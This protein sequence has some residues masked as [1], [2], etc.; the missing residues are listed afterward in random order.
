M[1]RFLPFLLLGLLTAPLFAQGEGDRIEGWGVAKFDGQ[2]DLDRAIAASQEKARLDLSANILTY[3]N[4]KTTDE[5]IQNGKDVRERFEKVTVTKV[6]QLLREVH[7]DRPQVDHETHLVTTRA[8]V[9]KATARQIIHDAME[10]LNEKRRRYKD[11]LDHVKLYTDGSRYY[12]KHRVLKLDPKDLDGVQREMDHL[13]ADLIREKL[14]DI[15]DVRNGVKT[16]FYWS[17]P[18][19]GQFTFVAY[20]GIRQ[21]DWIIKHYDEEIDRTEGFRTGSPF[22]MGQVDDPASHPDIAESV[23]PATRYAMFGFGDRFA[24]FAG[25]DPEFDINING[26]YFRGEGQFALRASLGFSMGSN[27][28]ISKTNPGASMDDFRVFNF[29]FPLIAEAM[30]YFS[31]IK[32]D[33]HIPFVKAGLVGVFSSLSTNYA[34]NGIQGGPVDMASGF[35]GGVVF[36]VGLTIFHKSGIVLKTLDFGID[37]QILPNGFYNEGSQVG[38]GVLTNFGL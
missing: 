33:K 15:Q 24:Y 7:L 38:I 18:E 36:G 2:G 34:T 29:H 22:T 37:C 16:V 10:R 31:D 11:A 9:T 25:T 6:V 26:F 14:R 8:S 28:D 4:V 30:F 35:S 12:Y 13:K 23:L 19:D 21:Y 32:S 3:V 1:N 17:F 5:T 27:N 20:I